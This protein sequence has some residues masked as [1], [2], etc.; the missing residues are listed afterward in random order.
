MY[1]AG[2]NA[3]GD[4]VDAGLGRPGDWTEGGLRNKV[5]LI[6]RG[7]ITFAEKVANVTAAG[8]LG[9]IIV[10]NAPGAFTGTLR[11]LT[12]IPVVAMTQEDGTT[13]RQALR[14]TPVQ[15]E[16]AVDAEVVEQASRNVVAKR[17]GA[18]PDSIVVGGHFDSVPGS[19]GA[20]DNASG[21]AVMLEI[22][23][24]FAERDYPL[25]LYFIAF[26]AEE[27]GLRGSQRFVQQLTDA[28]RGELR[29]MLNL[30]MIGVGSR[31]RVSGD[32]D[33]VAHARALAA[34]DAVSTSTSN[35]GNG[36]G[37]SDHASFERAGIPAL[38][39]NAGPDPNYHSPRDRSEFIDLDKLSLIGRLAIDVLESL[40]VPS[41]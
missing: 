41:N 12:E 28:S 8:A 9:A 32:A 19:P 10:N 1:S 17:S 13:L 36:G 14:D 15:I 39:F 7:E 21:T 24:Y 11:S 31:V 40:A 6:E 2:G 3:V 5:A 29:A 22:A 16:I 25:T 30:D 18:K 23:R 27:I 4:L 20:N 34:D 33:L 38:F 37:S 26:G 35:R